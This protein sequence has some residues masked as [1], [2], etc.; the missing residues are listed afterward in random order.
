MV[1]VVESPKRGERQLAT[2]KTLRQICFSLAAL[3]FLAG[4]L[5]GRALAT[6][7]GGDVGA[8]PPGWALGSYRFKGL[9]CARVG[10]DH[11]PSGGRTD[12]AWGR[13]PFGSEYAAPD[14]RQ[15]VTASE[16]NTAR[17]WDAA[18]GRAVGEPMQHGGRSPYS[19]VQSGRPTSVN[20]L[21]G[22]H[23]AVVGCSDGQRLGEPMKH[24]G[25]VMSVQFSPDGQRV[26]TAS[27]AD[28]RFLRRAGGAA[29]GCGNR[30]IT[31]RADEA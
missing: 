22:S 6:R 31:R 4:Q 28:R 26:L 15:V 25:G 30:Q 2:A 16:D 8:V 23:G 3:A 10:R 1:R 9:Y 20:W 17:L 12:E 14:G 11:R 5:V 18:T 7:G 21:M 19:P 29:V 24:E 27:W 13:G